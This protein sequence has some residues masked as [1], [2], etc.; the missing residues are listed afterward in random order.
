MKA[1]VEITSFVVRAGE[2]TGF[3][4]APFDVA[5]AGIASGNQALLKAL[6]NKG[7]KLAH[8]KAA[9][10]AL[11]GL[12]ITE[13]TWDR[14]NQ[15]GELTKMTAL[16]EKHGSKRKAD[17]SMDMSDSKQTV[18]IAAEYAKRIASGEFTILGGSEIDLG[19]GRYVRSFV[20]DEG[21]SK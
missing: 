7:I 3:Y 2:E 12:G 9:I 11:R 1:H 4:G 13:I 19:G 8:L 15:Q 21:K 6:T 10:T 17:G 16:H 5:V 18:A 14:V 20:I